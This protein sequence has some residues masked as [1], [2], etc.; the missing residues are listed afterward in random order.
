MKYDVVIVGAGPTGLAAALELERWGL[1]IRIVDKL[2]NPPDTSRAVGVQART[3]ELLAQ[4]GL[5]ENLLREGNRAHAVL[6][7]DQGRPIAEVPFSELPSRFNYLLFVS[8]A[9]TEKTLA[10]ALETTVERGTR[11]IALATHRHADFVDLV[12]RHPDGELEAVQCSYLLDAEG[13]HSTVRHTLGLKFRGE[14]L[15]EKFA[16]GDLQVEGSVSSSHLHIFASEHGFMGLFPMGG[17]RFR[18]IVSNPINYGEEPG[19]KLASLQEAYDQRS[20]TPARLAHLTWSSWFTVNSRMTEKLNLGRVFLAGDSAHIHSPA[21]AQG[22]NTGIQDVINLAWKMALVVQGKAAPKLL[23]TYQQERLPVIESLLSQTDEITHAM[24]S[25]SHLFRA[26]FRHLAPV[27]AA[28]PVVQHKATLNISQL[29]IN[30]RNS[31]LSTQHRISGEL[32]AGDRIEKELWTDPKSLRLLVSGLRMP[33]ILQQE[34]SP[35]KDLISIHPV[36]SERRF[37]ALARPDGYLGFVGGEEHL[38]ELVEYLKEW[39][40]PTTVNTQSPVRLS[41]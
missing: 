9:V 36:P 21:G 11:L 26:F 12:L 2:A 32:H 7:Y 4:R 33:R 19:P 10:S 14:T 27:V 40:L 31:P 13:A 20:H 28:R 37:L 15:E 38:S 1:N 6:I 39:F 17:N 8:Q 25:E 16:L 29:A 22:M 3:L 41:K 24:A 30:Y 35:W 18:V 34:L 5:A 23:D